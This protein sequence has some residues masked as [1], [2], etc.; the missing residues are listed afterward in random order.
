MF[1]SLE[2]CSDEFQYPY[3]VCIIGSGIAGHAVLYKIITSQSGKH[4]KIA[5][6]EGST[7]SQ[8]RVHR[9]EQEVE[10]YPLEQDLYAGEISGWINDSQP[11]YLITSRQR[12]FGG[13]TNIWSGWCWPLEKEDMEERPLRKGFY[14]PV[15]Y[16]EMV[17]YFQQAQEFCG[18]ST[19]QYDS[20]KYWVQELKTRRL[21]SMSLDGSPYK[22]RMLYFNP[23]SIYEYYLRDL[24]ASDQVDIFTNAHCLRLNRSP[25]GEAVDSIMLSSIVNGMPTEPQ[26]LRAKKYIVAAGCFETTRLLL[27]S[28]FDKVN[29][30]VGKNFMEH[31]YLWVASKF[32]FNV[33]PE[34]IRNFYFPKHPVSLPSQ[35]GIIPA[36]IPTQSF[37]QEN[38]I[39]TF[40]VLLGGAPHIPGTINISGS[41]CPT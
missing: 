5:M 1:R 10:H 22:T 39:G 41:R 19:Y 21:A 2:S 25:L 32:Q 37:I 27:N 8:R 24:A 31:P 26:E 9:L 36:L 30:N 20:A 12:A 40:R 18:L 35:V 7:Q 6:I 38:D 17:K 33:V 16:K 23:S 29:F 3:D 14:W 4:L 28:D 34:D 11:Q 15:S 13:T